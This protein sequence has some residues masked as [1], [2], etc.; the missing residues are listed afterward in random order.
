MS[1][2]KQALEVLGGSAGVLAGGG[3]QAAQNIGEYGIHAAFGAADFINRRFLREGEN[4]I[5][6]E[7][8]KKG[9]G[10]LFG[11]AILGSIG[12]AN[13]AL[14]E[15]RKGMPAGMLTPT[16]VIDGP[17]TDFYSDRSA[18]SWGAGGDINFAL[19]SIRQGTGRY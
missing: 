2:I 5:G 3:Y 8:N 1:K 4:M 6:K 16:P 13:D 14:T 15:S 10:V 9:K 12:G 19:S 17:G 7:L 11:G 18:E